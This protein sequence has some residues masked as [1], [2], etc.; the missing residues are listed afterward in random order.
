MKKMI[1]IAVLLV[2]CGSVCYA[3]E[4]GSGTQAT[5]PFTAA[6]AC[7][8]KTAA[9]PFQALCGCPSETE[10]SSKDVSPSTQK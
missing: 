8:V 7:V 4:A 10:A 2:F 5:D 6:C 1:A 9:A 3:A